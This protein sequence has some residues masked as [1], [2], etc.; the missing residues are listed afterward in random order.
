VVENVKMKEF[1]KQVFV[2]DNIKVM[3]KLT[4]TLELID[5]DDIKD[6]LRRVINGLRLLEGMKEIGLDD[7][8]AWNLLSWICLDS[9]D[10]TSS[11]SE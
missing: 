5:N 10:Y 2:E 3:R 1:S 6:F 7:T 9:S 8:E 4:V 11:D